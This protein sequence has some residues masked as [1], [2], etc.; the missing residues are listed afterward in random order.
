MS[1]AEEKLKERFPNIE[2]LVS[3]RNRLWREKN[4]Q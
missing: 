2:E 4:R 1:D 3:E